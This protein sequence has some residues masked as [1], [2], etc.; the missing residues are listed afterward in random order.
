[1]ELPAVAAA[2][3]VAME[4]AAQVAAMAQGA[5]REDPGAGATGVRRLAAAAVEFAACPRPLNPLPLSEDL[6]PLST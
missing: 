1:M 6:H 4:R 5:E 3:A 2:A